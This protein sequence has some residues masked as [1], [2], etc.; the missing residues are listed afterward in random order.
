MEVNEWAESLRRALP[1]EITKLREARGISKNELAART[2]L[3]RSFITELE[4]GRT[5]PSAETLARLGF[6]LGVSPGGILKNAEKQIEPRPRFR[7]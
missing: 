5:T 4:G 1:A 3:A 6:V 7:K 2:G